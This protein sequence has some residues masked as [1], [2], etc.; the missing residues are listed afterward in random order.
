M[1]NDY[2]Q[3]ISNTLIP[4]LTD[5]EKAQLEMIRAWA[6]GDPPALSEEG[7]LLDLFG[8]LGT[9]EEEVRAARKERRILRGK[10]GTPLLA[11]AIWT[12]SKEIDTYSI[13]GFRWPDED[14]FTEDGSVADFVASLCV[15]L[16]RIH[17]EEENY[18]SYVSIEGSYWGDKPRPGSYGGVGIFVTAD[19]AEYVSTGGF[20]RAKAKAHVLRNQRRA[21][22]L[23]K[24][25]L[26]GAGFERDD[27]G[28]YRR[29]AVLASIHEDRVSFRIDPASVQ[30]SGT[31]ATLSADLETLSQRL[32]DLGDFVQERILIEILSAYVDALNRG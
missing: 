19:G 5:A 28:E 21:A 20:L 31:T 29:G 25:T 12:A 18:P 26:L 13:Q 11:H 24:Q 9:T 15:D 30:V 6:G 1:S 27:S 4:A 22:S 8:L 7:Y 32:H 23:L 16:L 3:F 17:A 2:C 14:L 10:D